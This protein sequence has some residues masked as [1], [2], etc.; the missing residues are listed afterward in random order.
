MAVDRQSKPPIE[1]TPQ[2]VQNWSF[3]NEFKVLAFLGL[4]Y[5]GASLHRA[6]SKLV[7]KKITV[8]GDDTYIGIAP[9]GTTQATAAWQCKKISVSGNDT[10]IT[11]A[12]GDTSFDNVA[13]DLTALTYS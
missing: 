11:W 9:P 4:D 13:T 5:D 7:A 12:D 8:D 2:N 6:I 3:D 1:R 10:T